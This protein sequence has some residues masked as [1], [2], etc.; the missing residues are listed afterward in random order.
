MARACKQRTFSFLP[1]AK[2]EMERCVPYMDQS[3]NLL[4]RSSWSKMLYVKTSMS[5]NMSNLGNI[6][7]DCLIKVPI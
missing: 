5:M 4:C 3:Y 7:N 1:V 2:N 6:V